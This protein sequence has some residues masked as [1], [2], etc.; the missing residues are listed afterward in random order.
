MKRLKKLRRW[1]DFSFMLLLQ[2]YGLCSFAQVHI[3][4]KVTDANGK[5]IPGISVSVSNT[6]FGT[7]TDLSG[8]IYH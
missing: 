4:G 6:S 7:S 2:I 3:S 1:S 8:F 5:E